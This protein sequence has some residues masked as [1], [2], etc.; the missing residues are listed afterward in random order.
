MILSHQI[1][2]ASFAICTINP[3]TCRSNAPGARTGGVGREY[4]GFS[5]GSG[6]QYKHNPPSGDTGQGPWIRNSS[7]LEATIAAVV[8]MASTALFPR[9]GLVDRERAA[10][11]VLATHSVTVWE[12]GDIQVSFS[13]NGKNC[14]VRR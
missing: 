4:A 12:I 1:L 9:P 2:G 5:H 14:R 6:S 11:V 13:D 3:R 7:W 10:L 8:T